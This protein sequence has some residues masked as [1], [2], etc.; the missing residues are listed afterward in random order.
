MLDWLWKNKKSTNIQV[1]R[2]INVGD[3]GKGGAST[4]IQA[5]E[6][7]QITM[8]VSYEEL[9]RRIHARRRGLAQ[10]VLTKA[11][12]MIREAGVQ[13]GPVPMKTVV[14]LLEYASLEEDEYLRE[15]WAAVL[16][17][18]A[19][20]SG[21]VHASFAEVLR[22]LTPQGVLFL[23]AL[24]TLTEKRMAEF[25]S[26]PPQNQGG[27]PAKNL[28]MQH[29][30]LELFRKTVQIANAD[31]VG[32]EFSIVLTNLRRSNVV[33]GPVLGRTQVSFTAFGLEFIRSCRPP[34]SKIL[35]TPTPERGTTTT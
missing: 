20:S 11:Q 18:A 22:Q 34:E 26:Q 25:L 32:S 13:P 1:G 8:S 5:G 27:D 2:D 3:D 16:A 33:E 35:E 9:D 7:V 4:M 24:F 10:E 15:K 21:K 19:V 31:D 28:G 29:E 30:L 14:P 12:E 6:K 17:N 23:D